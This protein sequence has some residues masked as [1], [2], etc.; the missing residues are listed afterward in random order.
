MSWWRS[1]FNEVN[2]WA[3]TILW[4]LD[5][6]KKKN[7]EEYGELV[8]DEQFRQELEAENNNINQP[9]FDWETFKYTCEQLQMD[10]LF[11]E[12]NIR[13]SNLLFLYR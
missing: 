5:L 1:V 9:Q 12:R 11:Q 7:D 8:W 2:N 4:L 6:I 3:L 13:N 10:G